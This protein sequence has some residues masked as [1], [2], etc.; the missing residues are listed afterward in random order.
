MKDNHNLYLKCDV[1]LLAD[2]LEKFRDGCLE[3]YIL[4]SNHYLSGPA[5]SW[6][7]MLSMTEVELDL[8]SDVGMYLF[9]EK[10]MRG[11]VSYISKRHSKANT[12]DPKK[13][14][15]YITYFV[16]NDLYSCAIYNPP[17]T[18]VFNLLDPWRLSFRGCVLEVDLE[19][20]KE[21]YELKT[22]NVAWLSFKNYWWL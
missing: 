15:K 17:P 8:I 1:L 13:P 16:K 11:G 21:L 6:D 3:N 18:G 22:G 9:F 4:C 19:Y 5:L 20:S 7:A 12:C 10:G 14:T 2:V